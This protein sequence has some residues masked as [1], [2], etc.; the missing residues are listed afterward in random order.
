MLRCLRC[1]RENTDSK[2]DF[3]LEPFLIVVF[4]NFTTFLQNLKGATKVLNCETVSNEKLISAIL[5]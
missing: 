3:Y 5:C 4:F 2:L 1:L